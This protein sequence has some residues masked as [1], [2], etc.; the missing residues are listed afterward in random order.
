M[1]NT[2]YLVVTADNAESKA[3]QGIADYPPEIPQRVFK[4]HEE[5]TGETRFEPA[6]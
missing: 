1:F 2:A 3:I 6:T 5:S 4:N